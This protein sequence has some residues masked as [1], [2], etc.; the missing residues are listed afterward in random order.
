MIDAG[1]QRAQQLAGLGQAPGR[2]HLEGGA[3]QQPLV[4]EDHAGIVLDDQDRQAG[5]IDLPL[6]GHV[7]RTRGGA[8]VSLGW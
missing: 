6:H 5:R 8:S 1:P 7:A 2:D 3:A 4:H